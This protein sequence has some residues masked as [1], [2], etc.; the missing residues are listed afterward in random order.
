[1]HALVE[2][3]T[4]LISHNFEQRQTASGRDG[5]PWAWK[6]AAGGRQVGRLSTK[7]SSRR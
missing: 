5:P 2:Q 1:M 7:H 3:A 6:V 4:G